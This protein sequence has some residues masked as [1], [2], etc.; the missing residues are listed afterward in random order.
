MDDMHAYHPPLIQLK[1]Q[2]GPYVRI[3]RDEQR[4]KREETRATYT[5]N[6]HYNRLSWNFPC[7]FSRS[8]LKTDEVYLYFLKRKNEKIVGN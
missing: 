7:S 8:G 3:L 1:V 6:F 2:A 5:T 4:E